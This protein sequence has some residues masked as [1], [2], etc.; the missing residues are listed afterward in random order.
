MA[1][2]QM[3]LVD[4]IARGGVPTPCMEKKYIPHSSSTK[5]YCKQSSQ[6]RLCPVQSQPTL[7]PHSRLSSRDWG[8]QWSP[9][10]YPICT[11]PASRASSPQPQIH[12]YHY[13]TDSPQN[14]TGRYLTSAPGRVFREGSKHIDTLGAF[15]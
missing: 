13:L 12:T 2:A 14:I 7:G 4:R 8:S 9:H 1:S 6:W 5:T 3:L 15:F 11:L 10:T